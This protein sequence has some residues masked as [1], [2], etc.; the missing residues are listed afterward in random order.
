MERFAPG[1]QRRSF[2]LDKRVTRGPRSWALNARAAC[3]GEMR[4]YKGPTSLQNTHTHT[5][6]GRMNSFQRDFIASHCT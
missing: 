3:G 2:S 5:Q 4:S 6:G 1:T